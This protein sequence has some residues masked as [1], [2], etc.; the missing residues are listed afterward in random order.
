MNR[1]VTRKNRYRPVSRYK[2]GSSETDQ[3]VGSAG[4]DLS[5]YRMFTRKYWYRLVTRKNSK[6]SKSTG[7][8]HYGIT[9]LRDT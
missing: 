9:G 2:L 5:R 1:L 6:L 3:L 7:F 4:T 8:F